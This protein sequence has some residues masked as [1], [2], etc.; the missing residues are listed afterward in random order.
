MTEKGE[1]E[2]PKQRAF[3]NFKFS[4]LRVLCPVRRVKIRKFHYRILLVVGGVV[5][6]C[7]HVYFPEFEIHVVVA[8]NTMFAL[9]PTV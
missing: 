5:I 8:V 7:A 6:Y 1:D 2:K 3:H 4:P 9:D